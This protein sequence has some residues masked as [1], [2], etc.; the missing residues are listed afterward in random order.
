[1]GRK[2]Q[3]VR[4]FITLGFAMAAFLGTLS[5]AMA[6]ERGYRIGQTPDWVAPVPAFDPSLG[7]NA[8]VAHGFHDRLSDIQINAINKGQRQVYNAV[9]YSLTN[10][11]GVENFSDIEISFEPGYE[12]L[13]LHELFIQRG[14]ETINKLDSSRFDLLRT[15]RDQAKLIYNGTVTL[16]VLMDDVRVGDTIRYAY[17]VDGENPVFQGHREF[18]INTELWTQL[19]F[20]LN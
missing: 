6:D 14:T 12:T 2:F 10:H 16:A 8:T 18:H 1:M 7:T 15:E 20:N 4:F 13:T 11:F 19:P 3:L 9:E 5:P 17:T